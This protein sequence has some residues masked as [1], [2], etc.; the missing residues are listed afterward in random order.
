MKKSRKPEQSDS[1]SRVTPYELATL[2]S[3][4]NPDLCARDPMRALDDALT[5]LKN[6]EWAL[7]RLKEEE[8]ELDEYCEAVVS[9]KIRED[10]VRGIKQITG[11]RRLDRATRKFT[12][13]MEHEEPGSDLSHYQIDGFTLLEIHEFERDFAN[14]KKQPKRKKGKQG[15]RISERDGRLRTELVGLAPTKPRKPA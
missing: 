13:F 11:E 10:W 15:R 2:A 7:Y 8:K 6:A 12:D 3:R 14:L 5:F 1:T 9:G 4:I